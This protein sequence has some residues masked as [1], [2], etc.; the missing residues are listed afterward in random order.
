MPDRSDQVEGKVKE[1][2]GKVTGDDR[3]ESEGRTERSTEDFKEKMES[4]ADQA[5]GAAEAVK[6][7]FQ[8]K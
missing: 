2:A 1:V 8:G 7:K 5:R 6:E 4:G 3:M